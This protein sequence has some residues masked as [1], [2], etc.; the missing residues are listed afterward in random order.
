LIPVGQK[1]LSDEPG[2]KSVLDML[3]NAFRGPKNA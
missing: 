1:D 2:G 3:L